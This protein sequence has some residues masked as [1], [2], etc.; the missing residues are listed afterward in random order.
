ML[1]YIHIH[2]VRSE[3]KLYGCCLLLCFIACPSLFLCVWAVFLCVG[4]GSDDDISG[5]VPV[6]PDDH[7][8]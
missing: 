7:L 3:F 4:I 1:Y 2:N 5:S 6:L 8:K